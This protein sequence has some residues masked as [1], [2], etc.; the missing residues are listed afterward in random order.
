MKYFEYGVRTIP[1]EGH[2]GQF[3]DE[4]NREFS[5]VMYDLGMLG[6]KGWEV[7]QI[8]E[9]NDFVHYFFKREIT[10]EQAE[11]YQAEQFDTDDTGAFASTIGFVDHN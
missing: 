2:I 6:C 11:A 1:S 7:F 9:K 4:A 8:I 10:K 5:G 3:G